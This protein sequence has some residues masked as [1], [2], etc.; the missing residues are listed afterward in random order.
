MIQ[1]TMFIATF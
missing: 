1:I